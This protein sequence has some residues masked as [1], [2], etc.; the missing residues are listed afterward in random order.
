[1]ATKNRKKVKKKTKSR[2]ST[3][4]FT[5]K[6][7]IALVLVLA[8][9]VTGIFFAVRSHRTR[10]AIPYRFGKE[11]VY[12]ID[13][14]SHNGKVD[15]SQAKKEIDF[16]FIRVGCRG[17]DTGDIFLDGR[18]RTNMKGAEK[19]DIPFGV[20]I[21]SQAVSEAEAIEEAK[22][23]LKNIR[24]YKVELPLV[25][26]FEY[27][28]KDGK[29]IGRLADADLNR[30]ERTNIINAFLKTVKDAGYTPALYASSYIYRSYIN[31]RSLEEGTVIWVADYNKK[32]TYG[33]HYDIWQFS[34][35]GK[36]SGV[37]SKYV[38]TN[39][40]FTNEE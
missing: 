35:K 40:W 9:A 27:P 13:V 19:A 7:V 6:R 1:M 14:S 23:L 2:K 29:Q 21:Y 34:E 16:A 12:G 22:F 25:F 5:A 17:Y 3:S 28:T 26:D 18:A 38:D 31:V 10:T 4:F 39:Y 24:G 30:R 20:Y 32:V 37:S 11:K 15:W 33:G 36:C 8:L